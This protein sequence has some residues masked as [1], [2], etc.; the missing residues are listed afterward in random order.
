MTPALGVMVTV[1]DGLAQTLLPVMRPGTI[2][3]SDSHA[4]CRNVH[5]LNFVYPVTGV[6]MQNVESYWNHVKTKFK[7]MK[8][9]HADILTSSSCGTG[10][11]H[12][13]S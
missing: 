3:Y 4:A 8:W 2:V 11:V 13:L 6:H 5:S 9:V 12:R 10:Q 7:R 1:P